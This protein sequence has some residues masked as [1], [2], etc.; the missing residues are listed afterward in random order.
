MAKRRPKPTIKEL[1]KAV[2]GPD[3]PTGGLI[4]DTGIAEA[5]ET[6]KGSFRVRAKAEVTQV[7]R[8]RQGIEVTELPYLCLLYTSPSPRDRG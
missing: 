5:L 1:M 4:V 2:P 7:T 6:G 8:A 3:F